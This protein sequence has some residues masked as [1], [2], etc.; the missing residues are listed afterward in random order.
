MVAIISS[1]STNR[2]L[3]QTAVVVDLYAHYLDVTRT[4]LNATKPVR[5]RTPTVVKRHLTFET[6]SSNL[7]S[8]AF[9]QVFRISNDDFELLYGKVSYL[10]MKNTEMGERSGRLTITPRTRLAITLRMLAGASY[11]DIMLSFHIG[12]SS[13]YQ[14]FHETRKALMKVLVLPGLPRSEEELHELCMGFK[15]S[16]RKLSPLTGCVGALDGIAIKIKKPSCPH[17]AAFYCRKGFYSLPVQALVDSRYRFL[18]VS[19]RCVGSTHDQLAHAVSELGQYL[20]NNKLQIE[21]WIAGDEAYLCTNSLICP[22]PISQVSSCWEDAF[23]FFLSSL[24]I[25]VEQAFGML[26]ARWRVLRDLEFSPEICSEIV[27]LCMK[28]HNFCIDNKPGSWKEVTQDDVCERNKD[29]LE[30]YDCCKDRHSTWV[31][32]EAMSAE[33]GRG[34]FSKREELVEVIRRKGLSRPAVAGAPCR[35]SEL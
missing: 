14:V 23:N 33:S 17:A 1:S 16:R 2:L 25:H 13:T 18:D 9:R 28:L 31:T 4:V 10:L 15:H 19:I 22:I 3:R 29:V 5:R 26:V 20:A 7:N 35:S 34:M 11:G 24:R 30:W 27:A 6:L 8:R 21:Y 32:G 12:R